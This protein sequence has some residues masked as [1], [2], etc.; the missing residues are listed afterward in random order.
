MVFAQN[1]S[2]EKEDR[3]QATQDLDEMVVTAGRV[4]EPIKYVVNNMAIIDEQQ[5]RLSSATDVGDL[6]AEQ[7]IGA[8][9]KYPGSLT[10]IGIRGFRTESHGNDLKGHVLILLNGR[11]AGTGNVAK[12]MTKNVERIE[13]IRGP[14]S[15]Q[16]G[17]AA[18]GGVVNVIT[19]QGKGEPTFFAEGVLGSFGNVEASAGFQGE[20][21]KFDFSGSVT[22]GNQDDYTTADGT[23]YKNTG[24][25]DR[26]NVSLNMGYTFLP[27]N[28]IG[29]M[30]NHFNVDGA[31]S[32]NYLSQNDL[33]DFTDKT[34]T[35][36]DV[37]L[38]GQSKNE[39]FLWTVR[40]FT[41]EDED[42][43]ADPTDSN[44]DGWDDGDYSERKTENQG[45]QAQVTG[46]FGNTKITAGVDWTN[47]DIEA[48]WTPKETSYENL[49]GFLLGK[50][51]FYDDRAVLSAGM[52]YDT[53]EVEV[54]EPSGNTADD[55]NLVPN[56]G[57]SFLVADGIKIRAA[58]SEAFVMPSADHMA[59]DWNNFG[60]NY[61]GNP[62]L[63]PE[64]SK[65]YEGGFD[66]FHRSLKGGLTYFHTDFKDKI[67]SVTLSNGD[68]SW[69]NLGKAKI[70]G[71]EGNFSCD[72]GAFFNWK[73]EVRPYVGFTY[74]T[75]YEDE[76]TGKDLLETSDISASYG[77]ILSDFEGFSTRLNFAYYGEKTITDYESGWPYED[78]KAG[79]FT[80]A[81][82]SVKKELLT[83]EKMGKLT[84]NAGVNNLF[85]EGYEF[86]K[87]YPMPGRNFYV[88]LRYDF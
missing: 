57:L 83:S 4:K 7:G 71:F 10:T 72:I 78:V 32:P 60:T 18:V 56:I 50:Y 53:Y 14:G 66:F 45:A 22:K 48:T 36:V 42:V 16:Y 1:L 77:L 59:A 80:V 82:F 35:S 58:Y 54:I 13:V 6:L 20:V 51:Q 75:K 30:V 64:S 8:I 52:R 34:N 23:T 74:L 49:A 68:R 87:G 12:I 44:P 24:V 88:G 85:D 47:Y 31:G 3:A 41:G 27:G 28:R 86:I 76:E 38:D 84:L 9:K 62:N 25:D 65:T 55:S 19:R 33:D 17:S 81:N 43:W 26:G 67:E 61:V 11:R 73:F 40:Y 21:S 46:N 39:M 63:S 29:I 79:S 69:E 2:G 5:I 15:V 37:I 70:S